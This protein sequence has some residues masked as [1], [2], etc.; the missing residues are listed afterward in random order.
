MNNFPE[1]ASTWKGRILMHISSYDDKNPE[2]KVAPL[3]S[4]FKNKVIEMGAF[5]YEE[6]EI[7]AEVGMGISLPGEKSYKVRI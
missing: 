1:T 7:I 4:E 3:D 6:F 2:M 5:A